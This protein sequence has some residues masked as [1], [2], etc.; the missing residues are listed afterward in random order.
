MHSFKPSHVGQR[1]I[2]T[3]H[4]DRNLPV[5]HILHDLYSSVWFR[6][7]PGNVCYIMQL[8]PVPPGNISYEV[9]QVRNLSDVKYL[10]HERGDR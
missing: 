4:L 5:R 9:I 1:T 8:I 6:P 2:Y 7:H 3:D 10:D